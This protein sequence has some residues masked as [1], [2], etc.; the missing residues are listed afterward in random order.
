MLRAL[1]GHPGTAVAFHYGSGSSKDTF[2]AGSAPAGAESTT[3]NLH[4]GWHVETLAA[5]DGSGV[6]GN[7]DA[8]ALLLGGFVLSLL[9]GVLIYVL[10]TGRSRA[11][12][13]CSSAPRNSTIWPSTTRSPGFPTEP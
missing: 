4:N 11:L 10:G 12:H 1:A 6:F 8:L 3:I 9:L 13:S 5:V 2:K 7:G